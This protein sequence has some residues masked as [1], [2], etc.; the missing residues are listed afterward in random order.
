MADTKL[1]KSVG[2]HWA[3][4]ELARW[5]W[6]AALTRDGLE[7]TDLLAVGTHLPDRPTIEIQVKTARG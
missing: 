6:A 4:S 3:C 2:E 1:T 7:R 5:G